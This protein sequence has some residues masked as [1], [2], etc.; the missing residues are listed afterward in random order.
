MKLVPIALILISS[1]KAPIVD[2]VYHW[3]TM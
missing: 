3:T 2:I 1:Y